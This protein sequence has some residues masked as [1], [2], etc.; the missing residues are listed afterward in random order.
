MP[1]VDW[2]LKQATTKN[3]KRTTFGPDGI[4]LFTELELCLHL[5]TIRIQIIGPITRIQ[6][7]SDN[8]LFGMLVQSWY[9]LSII[10][11]LMTFMTVFKAGLSNL[12]GSRAK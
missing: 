7:N 4:S 6:L 12:F 3:R 11:T 5:Y 2:A 8:H 9:F 10:K 1:G